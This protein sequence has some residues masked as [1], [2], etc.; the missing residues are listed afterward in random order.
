MLLVIHGKPAHMTTATLVRITGV[1]RIRKHFS[2]KALQPLECGE[3]I[4]R[5]DILI[6]YT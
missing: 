3:D 2:S 6:I 5:D 1:I 4:L